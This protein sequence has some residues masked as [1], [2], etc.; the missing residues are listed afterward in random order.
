MAAKA[1]SNR[2]GRGLASLIGDLEE[3]GQEAEVA[4][5][6][7]TVPIDSL[8][9]SKANPR[10]AFDE[11]E[12]DELAQS[13]RER[14]LIQPLLVRPIKNDGYEIVAGERRWRAAQR[15]NLHDVPVI[16]RQLTDQESLELAIIENVQRS[17]LNPIEEALGYRQLIQKFDHRQEDLAGIVGKSRSHLANMMRLLKLPKPVQEMVVDGRLS[18]G[19]AR[20]LIGRTDAVALAE[21]IIAEGLTVRDVERLVQSEEAANGATSP[22][23]KKKKDANVRAVETELS[24]VLGLTVDIA[25]GKGEAGELRIRYSSLDQFE[26]VRARLMK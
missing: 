24:E 22:R 20:A 14:G 21:R 9:A 17:D 5:G 16:I 2:L 11:A 19:H 26:A 13:I 12:L 7:E 15:A 3:P 1:K 10:R 23:P 18:S 6:S 8:K 25:S 4:L